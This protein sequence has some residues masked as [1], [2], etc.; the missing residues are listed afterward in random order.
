VNPSVLLEVAKVARV[1]R[2]VPSAAA[3]ATTPDPL[4]LRA[5]LVR[6]ARAA[7]LPAQAE[8]PA[9]STQERLTLAAKVALVVKRGQVEAK[10]QGGEGKAA[11]AG[12][13]PPVL[14]RSALERLQQCL[15]ALWLPLRTAM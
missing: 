11:Q 13:R 5:M 15:S 12:V 14:A 3:A 6:V 4:A 2:E 1:A 10:V 8:V 7:A 9:E